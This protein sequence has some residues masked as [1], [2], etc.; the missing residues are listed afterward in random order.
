VKS[1]YE[2]PE[3]LISVEVPP[4]YANLCMSTED[5]NF[6][7]EWFDFFGQFELEIRDKD[8]RYHYRCNHCMPG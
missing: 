4:I 2:Q 3:K 8:D 1:K 7:L 6:S 5:L